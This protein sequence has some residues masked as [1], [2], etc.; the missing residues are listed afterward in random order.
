M[1]YRTMDSLPLCNPLQAARRALCTRS[2][3]S[4]CK[5]KATVLRCRKSACHSGKSLLLQGP[6]LTSSIPSYTSGMHPLQSH[7]NVFTQLGT[8]AA[9]SH[10]SEDNRIKASNTDARIQSTAS[11]GQRSPSQKRKFIRANS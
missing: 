1:S 2:K 8:N 7:S 10:M 4:E 9:S 3:G 11:E 5:R 6:L